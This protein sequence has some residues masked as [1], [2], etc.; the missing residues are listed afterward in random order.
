MCRADGVNTR[1]VR[2]GQADLLSD[3]PE[4]H[5][6]LALLLYCA[7]QTRVKLVQCFCEERSNLAQPL[8]TAQSLQDEPGFKA[9]VVV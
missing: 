7:A 6:E 2:R 3:P 8:D 4:P 9:I 5:S 1:P